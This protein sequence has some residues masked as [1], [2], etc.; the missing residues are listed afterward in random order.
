MG[1][2]DAK[3]EITEFGDFECPG[4]GEF[5]NVTEPDI[6]ERLV[7]PGLARFRFVDFPL[8]GHAHAMSAHVAAACADEQGKFWEIHDKLFAGQGQ[9]SAVATRNP[10][11]VFDGYIRE[12]GLDFDKWNTCYEER[13]PLPRIMANKQE[14][15]RVG[16]SGTPTVIIGNLKVTN[17]NF[18]R[19]RQIVDSLN[20]EYSEEQGGTKDSGGKGG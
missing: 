2:P 9:W 19:I 15:I 4:C 17:A 12:A 3:V 14:G 16:V 20:R 5:A 6:R 1:S 10:K 18:D 8:D 11:K 7:K 13:R